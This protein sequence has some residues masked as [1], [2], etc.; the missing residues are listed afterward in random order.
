[1]ISSPAA[2]HEHDTLGRHDGDD[3]LAVEGSAQIDVPTV[4]SSAGINLRGRQEIGNAAAGGA[5][6]VAPSYQRIR[7]IVL[8]SLNERVAILQ[9][10]LVSEYRRSRAELVV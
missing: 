9:G 4:A 5:Y 3:S 6:I 2:V 1:V 8:L 7:E 10:A